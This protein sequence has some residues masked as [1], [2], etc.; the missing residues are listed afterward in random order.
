MADTEPSARESAVDASERDADVDE[1][2][3]EAA[4]RLIR[5]RGAAVRR[6][7]LRTALSRLETHG[8]LASEQR[9]V[10]EEMA[11]AVVDGVL[12]APEST[13]ASGETDP[14]A[15]RTALELFESER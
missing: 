13:L 7:E 2:N 3:A 14:D 9:R 15:V 12:A 6:R 8:G 1:P 4:R 5:A 10:V 11:A